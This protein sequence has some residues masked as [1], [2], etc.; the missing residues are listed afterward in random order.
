[1]VKSFYLACL[2]YFKIL[3]YTL[4]LEVSGFYRICKG[5]PS[6]LWP[7][8]DRERLNGKRQRKDNLICHSAAGEESPTFIEFLI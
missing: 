5:D 3:K 7:Q 8:D 1:M 6:D 2:F 4:G